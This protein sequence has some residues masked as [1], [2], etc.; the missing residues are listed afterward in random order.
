MSNDVGGIN[1][2]VSFGRQLVITKS[3]KDWR[4]LKNIG[5][6]VIWFQSENMFPSISILQDLAS[7]FTNF[8]ILFDNDEAGIK[9]GEK[10]LNL[11]FELQSGVRRVNVPFDLLEKGV[12]DPSDL[13][14]RYGEVKLL[15][16]LKT[17]KLIR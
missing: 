12:K 10:L 1:S 5:L 8:T 4:V 13:R 11:L 7:R 3:Y 9:A 17:N 2:L 16:F 14:K 15:D 6:N